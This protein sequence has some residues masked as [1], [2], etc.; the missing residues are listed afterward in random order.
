MTTKVLYFGKIKK[1]LIATLILQSSVFKIKNNEL[2]VKKMLMMSFFTE[3][4]PWELL[5][6]F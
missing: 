5:E 1:A 6:T 4:L 3:S 2:N